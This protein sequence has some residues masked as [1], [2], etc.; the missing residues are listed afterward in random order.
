MAD[1]FGSDGCRYD[2]PGD[3]IAANDPPPYPA[4]WTTEQRLSAYWY[5]LN[6]SIQVRS[7]NGWHAVLA[8]A[9][10]TAK[11]HLTIAKGGDQ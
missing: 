8:D 4:E 10:R 7:T 1:Y 5:T 11:R 9:H 2:F 6:R 3:A